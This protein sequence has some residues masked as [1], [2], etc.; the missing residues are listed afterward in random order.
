MVL[1][2]MIFYNRAGNVDLRLGVLSGIGG[3]IGGW[4]GANILKKINDKYLILIFIIFLIYSA[5]LI[6]NK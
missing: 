2:S 3:L 6:F 1:A 4:F 5:I